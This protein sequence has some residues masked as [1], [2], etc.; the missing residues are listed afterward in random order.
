MRKVKATL[1]VLVGKDI[2]KM[3]Q[4]A[5]LYIQ[6]STIFVD[7][8]HDQSMSD[9]FDFMDF[10]NRD[11]RTNF[12]KEKEKYLRFGGARSPDWRLSMSKH[13]ES[14]ISKLYEIKPNES[15]SF[16]SSSIE[17]GRSNINSRSS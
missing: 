3:D 2:H 13:S 7:Q 5:E 17:S 15:L 11:E 16:I 9:K 14:K 8:K 4:I 6:N 12:Q 1:S 10:L